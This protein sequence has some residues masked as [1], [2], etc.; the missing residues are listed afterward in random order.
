MSSDSTTDDVREWPAEV[1]APKSVENKLHLVV[2]GIRFDDLSDAERDRLTERVFEAVAA[3]CEFDPIAVS[4]TPN[5]D[6]EATIAVPH[7]SDWPDESDN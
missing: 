6:E 2:D 5:P 3:T 7:A 4:V 1:D